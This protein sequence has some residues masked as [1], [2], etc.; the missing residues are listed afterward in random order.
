MLPG[1]AVVLVVAVMTGQ[2]VALVDVGL[3]PAVL[4]VSL[5]VLNAVEIIVSVKAA[6][7]ATGALTWRLIAASSVLSL[8]S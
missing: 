1:V 2:A 7:R 3:R 5:L 4:R 6:R 8:L